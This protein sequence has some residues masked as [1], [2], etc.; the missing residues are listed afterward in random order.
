MSVTS[1]AKPMATAVRNEGARLWAN[2]AHNTTVAADAHVPGPGRIRPR[3]KNVPASVA[4][5]GVGRDA[6]ATARGTLALPTWAL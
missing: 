1:K 2:A 4:H 3:P 5:S 6:P